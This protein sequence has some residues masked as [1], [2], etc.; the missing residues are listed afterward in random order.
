MCRHRAK[1][2]SSTRRDTKPE[3]RSAAS[4]IDTPFW[5][6]RRWHSREPD[7]DNAFLAAC[8]LL[9]NMRCNQVKLPVI[10]ITWV[11]FGRVW[12]GSLG[13]VVAGHRWFLR[14]KLG[15]YRQASSAELP[16]ALSHVEPA[17]LIVK[18]RTSANTVK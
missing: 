17:N 2:G 7:I 10:Q 9:C 4:A 8:G 14:S 13:V 18:C 11:A 12:C 15:Q 3:N 5:C 1:F 6:G 16:I